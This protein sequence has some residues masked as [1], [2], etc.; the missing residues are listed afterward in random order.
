M[1]ITTI[2]LV[3]LTLTS[4]VGA[5]LL[6]SDIE[7]RTTQAEKILKALAGTYSLVNTSRYII[8]SPPL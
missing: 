4:M 7:E 2:P 3:L 5:A 1:Q 8:P 6:P